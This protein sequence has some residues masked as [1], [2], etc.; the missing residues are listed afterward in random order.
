M[1]KVI[2][3]VCILF[4]LPSVC[5]GEGVGGLWNKLEEEKKNYYIAGYIIGFNGARSL[6]EQS[7][8]D[9][10]PESGKR[11]IALLN[12]TYANKK[13]ENTS[14]SYA[15]MIAVITVCHEHPDGDYWKR[16]EKDWEDSQERET[17]NDPNSPESMLRLMNQNARDLMGGG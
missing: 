14:L 7:Q 13:Y 16:I 11:I 15:T 10:D 12:Q 9:C 3:V 1:R 8:F 4:C 6:S 5:R 2:L 17:K